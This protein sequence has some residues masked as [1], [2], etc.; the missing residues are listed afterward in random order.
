MDFETYAAKLMITLLNRFNGLMFVM[1]CQRVLHDVGNRV[2]YVVQILAQDW[3]RRR[4][5]VNAVMNVRI[6]QNARNFLTNC[7]PLGF[8]RRTLL[9]VASKFRFYYVFEDL[10]TV[11]N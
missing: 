7:E 10:N 2:L 4:A 5:L 11:R 1:E 6:S 3:D 8:S 9:H